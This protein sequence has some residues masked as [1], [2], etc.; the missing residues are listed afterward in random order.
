MFS[1]APSR[2]LP[3]HIISDG[4]LLFFQLFDQRRDQVDASG[5]SSMIDST[6]VRSLAGS[7]GFLADSCGSPELSRRDAD[8]QRHWLEDV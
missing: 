3:Q 1:S 6:G 5:L 8:R 2:P 4:I 7:C